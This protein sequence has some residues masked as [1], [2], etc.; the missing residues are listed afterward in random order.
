METTS[1]SHRCPCCGETLFVGPAQNVVLRAC[2][3]C[4]GVW[5][6][7]EDARR[8]L[9]GWMSEKGM[10]L[11]K[12]VDAGPVGVGGDG[13][14]RDAGGGEGRR[15]ACPHCGAQLESRTAGRG[16]IQVQ[17]DVCPL[18]CAWFDRGELV[19]I[20]TAAGVDGRGGRLVRAATP[21]AVREQR[22]QAIALM[23]AVDVEVDLLATSE[24]PLTREAATRL[25]PLLDALYAQLAPSARV[26]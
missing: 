14:Y 1:A 9:A 23:T 7:L 11:A 13:G 2:N 24:D 26:D 8:A 3:S 4:R 22:L 12:R 15:R 21:A 18:H 19:R 25:R 6:D 20:A 10:T 16:A 5:L 17:L